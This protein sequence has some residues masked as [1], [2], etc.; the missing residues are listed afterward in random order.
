MK[1]LVIAALAYLI[2]SP[3][4][5]EQIEMPHAFQGEWCGDGGTCPNGWMTVTKSGFVGTSGVRCDLK[6]ALYQ[7]QETDYR[8]YRGLW[9]LTFKCTDSKKL[10]EEMWF[11]VD[12]MLVV[13]FA[14]P[15]GSQRLVQYLPRIKRDQG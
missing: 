7:A 12:E 13:T 15:N 6:K 4:A 2:I 5:A 14:L 10:V 1:Y 8:H 3:A 11:F 9:K